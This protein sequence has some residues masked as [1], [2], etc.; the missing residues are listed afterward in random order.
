MTAEERDEI[1]SRGDRALRRGELAEAVTLFESL[2][3][4]FP[5]DGGLRRKLARVR[6]SLQ[7]AE[8]HSAKATFQ[9][10]GS[11]PPQ[12]DS[13]EAEGERLLSIGDHPG[14]I[15]AYRRALEQ[16]P[17]SELIRDRLGELFRQVQGSAPRSDPTALLR[18]LLER[19]TSRRKP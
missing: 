2:A 11:G 12:E 1:E 5:D 8:L 10:S 16:K 6:E 7:P 14:A 13:L 19:V 15:A 3:A 4:A 17:D 9:D 18:G